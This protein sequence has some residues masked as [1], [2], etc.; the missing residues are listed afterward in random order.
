MKNKALVILGPTASG[1]TSLA[2]NLAKHLKIEII[3]LDSALIYREMDIG[4]AKPTR[5][6]LESVPH[7]LI[8]IC[9][10]AQSYSAANF[11]E[12]CIRLVDEITKRG[13]LPVIC[14]GTMMYYKALVDGLSPL[15]QTDPKVREKIASEAQVCGWPKMHERL[16]DVDPVSYEKLNPND[17]QRVSRALEIY[18]MTGRAMSSFFDT[19]TDSCPFERLEFILLPKND[20]RE[21]LRKLIRKRFELMVDDGLIDEV[22]K[23]KSRGDLNLDMPSMRCVG[24]RQVWEYLDGKYDKNEMVEQCVIATAHLAKH[25]MTWLRG[26]LSKDQNYLVKKRLNIGDPDNLKIVLD[27]LKEFSLY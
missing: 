7:H 3:S 15:P 12:D 23:L 21:E 11:R 1:K 14:G 9:D 17:K 26:S 22:S 24:Y 2:L 13:A 4:T 16:K 19:K 10:P 18:E 25:Q 20:D 8:D 27:S 5:E 6:E